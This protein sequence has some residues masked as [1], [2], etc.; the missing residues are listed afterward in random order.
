MNS[1]IELSRKT[2]P[3]KKKCPIHTCTS[4]IPLKISCHLQEGVGI[5]STFQ[6][7]G[8]F[9]DMFSQPGVR[10]GGQFLTL[11]QGTEVV[12]LHESMIF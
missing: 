6:D 11:R 10:V 7:L 5:I 12:P 9:P 1:S 4:R 2:P 8:L 3:T